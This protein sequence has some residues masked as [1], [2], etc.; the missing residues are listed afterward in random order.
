MK[1]WFENSD[2]N[3]RLIADCRDWKDVNETIDDFIE[4]C[5]ARKIAAAIDKHGNDFDISKV[6]L[7]KRYYTRTWKQDDGRTKIDV[8]SHTEFFITQ[9]EE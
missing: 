8:G 3:E 9:E 4:N 7:F 1:L 5:N 6:P 2:G